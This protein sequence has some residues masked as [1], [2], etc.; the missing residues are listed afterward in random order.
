MKLRIA[1]LLATVVL[2]F[3]LLGVGAYVTAGNYGA[4][5]GVGTSSDWPECNGNLFP[6]LV[7]GAIVEYTHRVLASLSGLFM[8]LT[9]VTFWRAKDA[10]KT[11]KRLVLLAL[12]SIIV[13]IF[14]GG[15]VVDSS[16]SPLVVTL[17]QMIAVL[18]FGFTVGAAATAL[19]SR[20]TP[21]PAPVV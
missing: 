4:A 11:S 18:V 7:F 13:E 9:A 15:A 21:T 8:V 10:G 1:L 3:A 19:A 17:H 6:P 5:C 14:V 2:L 16:L 20:P 12:V